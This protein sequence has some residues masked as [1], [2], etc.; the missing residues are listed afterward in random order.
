[1]A[2]NNRWVLLWAVVAVIIS[3]GLIEG[4]L[5]SGGDEDRTAENEKLWKDY[6]SKLVEILNDDDLPPARALEILNLF[7]PR[8]RTPIGPSRLHAS[9]I[10]H[11][12]RRPAESIYDCY[13]VPIFERYQE[14]ENFNSLPSVNNLVKHSFQQWIRYCAKY[15]GNLV[16]AF[17]QLEKLSHSVD[18]P[19]KQVIQIL[20]QIKDKKNVEI[21]GWT[22]Q[23]ILKRARSGTPSKVEVK[24]C[25]LGELEK[26]HFKNKLDNN[27]DGVR[28]FRTNVANLHEN[29]RKELHSSCAR[30]FKQIFEANVTKN[31]K[32]TI[33]A[34]YRKNGR[35]AFQLSEPCE[36]VIRTKHIFFFLDGVY[37][38]IDQAVIAELRDLNDMCGVMWYDLP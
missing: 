15:H 11:H 25:Q 14:S 31:D 23:A 20:E 10:L 18:L 29:S 24:D 37:D 3:M 27:L 9:T 1:M 4:L 33:L 8:S 32:R 30:I 21:D 16:Q 2:A 6:E 22:V 7:H 35:R 19:N 13:F 17:Y 12:L 34:D 38:Q 26:R 36:R 28:Y 5:A